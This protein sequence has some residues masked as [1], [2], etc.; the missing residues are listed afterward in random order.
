MASQQR[1]SDQSYIRLQAEVKRKLA[2]LGL[3]VDVS[4]FTKG[5]LF[6]IRG[7]L[8]KR[9]AREH[10]RA[11]WRQRQQRQLEGCSLSHPLAECFSR[12]PAEIVC[13]ERAVRPAL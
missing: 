10:R 7:I 8:A 5:E 11:E 4:G 13:N 12:D 9:L 6:M 2:K 3:E 1:K